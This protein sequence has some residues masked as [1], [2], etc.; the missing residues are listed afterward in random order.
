MSAAAHNPLALTLSKTPAYLPE[1]G[2]PDGFN[3]S[4]EKGLHVFS[5]TANVFE[6]FPT[7][8]EAVEEI[9]GREH[10][11]IKVIVPKEW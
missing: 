5:P 10:G 1:G 6:D 4:M 9:A 2:I 11:V 8:L 3:L 7:F